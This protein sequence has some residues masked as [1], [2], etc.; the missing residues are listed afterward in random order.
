MFDLF[1]R[2]TVT[3]QLLESNGD[4]MSKSKYGEQTVVIRVP[5]S[6]VKDVREYLKLIEDVSLNDPVPVDDSSPDYRLGFRHGM[7]RAEE[8]IL[9]QELILVGDSDKLPMLLDTFR[10]KVPD[11]AQSAVFESLMKSFAKLP[12]DTFSRIL[13]PYAL[14]NSLESLPG[15]VPALPPT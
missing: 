13:S 15:Q 14:M 1:A 10:G 8:L 2:V 4:F 6:R 7:A 12:E 3:F 11:S 9:G 5:K